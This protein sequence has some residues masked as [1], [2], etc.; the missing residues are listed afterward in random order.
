MRDFP[1]IAS[2]VREGEEFV[3]YIQKDDAPN[4]K[5]FYALRTRGENPDDGDNDEDK[6]LRF[7]F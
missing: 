4:K 3:P 1:T 2:R 6:S 5:H 7:P